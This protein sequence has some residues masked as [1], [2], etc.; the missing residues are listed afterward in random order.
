MK[1][2]GFFDIEIHNKKIYK[3]KLSHN[4]PVRSNEKSKNREKPLNLFINFE[5]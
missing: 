3:L 4:L 5:N 2:I 1:L